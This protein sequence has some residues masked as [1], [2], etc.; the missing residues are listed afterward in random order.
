MDNRPW[1]NPTWAWENWCSS[2]EGFI[3]KHLFLSTTGCQTG[4]PDREINLAVIRLLRSRYSASLLHEN[5]SNT[6]LRLCVS[7]PRLCASLENP[8]RQPTNALRWLSSPLHHS[9]KP[10]GPLRSHFGPLHDSHWL[11]VAFSSS[12]L[13]VWHYLCLSTMHSLPLAATLITRSISLN[14][15]RCR[16]SNWLINLVYL[17]LTLKPPLILFLLSLQRTRLN[18]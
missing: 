1:K 2:S 9:R 18:L 15:P 7:P 13:V 16:K 4:S 6:S 8:L 14:K 11:C 5:L 10:S 17:Q 12:V 3:I